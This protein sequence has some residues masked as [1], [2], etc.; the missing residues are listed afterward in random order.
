MKHSVLKN[1]QVISYELNKY[2][3][4]F[5]GIYPYA[6]NKNQFQKRGNECEEWEGYMN[7]LQGGNGRKK[8][9]QITISKVKNKKKISGDVGF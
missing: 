7:T 3:Q 1:I 5:I 6:C 4:E 9:Y 8:Y 2:K